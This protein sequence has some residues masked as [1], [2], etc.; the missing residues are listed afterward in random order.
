MLVPVVK[1][2]NLF[3]NDSDERQCYNPALV[4]SEVREKRL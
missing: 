3:H 2:A 1:T 4:V